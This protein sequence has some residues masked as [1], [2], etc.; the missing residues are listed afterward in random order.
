MAHERLGNFEAAIDA[1]ETARARGA[2]EIAFRARILGALGHTYGRW[3]KPD[4]ALA[5]L[6]ELAA[7]SQSNYVDPFEIAHVHAGLGKTDA[8][9]DNLERAAADRSGWLVYCGVWPAFED[10][11]STTRFRALLNRMTL[12]RGGH[13]STW[14]TDNGCTTSPLGE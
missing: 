12:R 5:V 7:L 3:E 4:R 13:G 11:R 9:L 6:D 1:L 10:L 14:T 8:A 2:G